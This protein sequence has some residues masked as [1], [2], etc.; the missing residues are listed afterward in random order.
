MYVWV[1]PPDEGVG[2]A[3]TQS[4][5]AFANP[6]V[7]KPWVYGTVWVPQETVVKLNSAQPVE[8]PLTFLAMIFQKLVDPLA[9]PVIL[10]LVV[11][12]LPNN[13]VAPAV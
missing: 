13:T 6:I 8:S 12:M 2:D 10:T 3:V 11:A 9:T 4:A 1:F 7:S 5:N